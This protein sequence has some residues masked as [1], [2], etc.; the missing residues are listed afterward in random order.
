MVRCRV[1][2]EYYYQ[3]RRRCW[4]SIFP[5]L[6]LKRLFLS[7]KRGRLRR[8]C[9][10]PREED[11]PP[12]PPPPPPA[13]AATTTKSKRGRWK[14]GRG[15]RKTPFPD[16]KRG[17]AQFSHCIKRPEGGV[18]ETTGIFCPENFFSEGKRLMCPLNE[19]SLSFLCCVH[20]RQKKFA[21]LLAN[22]PT[23][24]SL[25]S[26]VYYRAPF[27]CRHVGRGVAEWRWRPLITFF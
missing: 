3:N 18:E 22:E 11:P 1:F 17:Q 8:I 2:V 14:E 24:L 21:S 4:H 20:R 26:F 7:S 12:P 25:P 16:K 23:K 27:L 15:G 13:A 10:T 19:N 5:L 6:S 9:Q